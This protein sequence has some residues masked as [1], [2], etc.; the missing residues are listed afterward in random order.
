MSIDV[1]GAF[2]YFTI[3]IFGGIPITQTTVSSFIVTV[4]LCTAFVVLGKNITKRPSKRQVL[5]EKGVTMITN[6]TASAMGAHNVHWAP[7]MGCLFLCS[8][9]GSYIGLTGFFRSATAVP[10]TPRPTGISMQA[11]LPWKGP[12]TSLPFSMM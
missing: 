8:I 11:G 3:P 2:V 1:T 4:L 12:S 9:C 7:F 6:L 10:Q 5:V